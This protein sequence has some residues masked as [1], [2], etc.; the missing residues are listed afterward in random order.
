MNRPGDLGFLSALNEPQLLGA[1][2]SEKGGPPYTRL[3]VASWPF[4]AFQNIIL[5]RPVVAVALAP[6][7]ESGGCIISSPSLDANVVVGREAPWQGYL[8][9][10]ITLSPT[11][12]AGYVTA[13]P[14]PPALGYGHLLDLMLYHA[15]QPFYGRRASMRKADVLVGAASAPSLY[16]C[17]SG[18]SKVRI[19]FR[20]TAGTPVCT[21]YGVWFDAAD[22]IATIFG[23]Q[24]FSTQWVYEFDPKNNATAT[25]STGVSCPDFIQVTNTGGVGNS[26]AFVV[27]A[28]D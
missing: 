27:V 19:V 3:R 1:K 13:Q 10:G 15:P 5:P 11:W 8:E 16:Y 23:T 22:K 14:A 12:A 20:A 4:P 6:G 25:G 24:A 7:D 9:G 26:A 21:V 2:A 28:E 17:T 18:R